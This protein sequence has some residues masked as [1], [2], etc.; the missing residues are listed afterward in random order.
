MALMMD[1]ICAE[2]NNYFVNSVED[3]HKGSFEISNGVITPSDFLLTGQYFRIVGSKLNDGVYKHGDDLSDLTDEVFDGAIWG[4]SVP[5][6]FIKTCERINEWYAKYGGVNSI[7]LS[8][9]TSESFAGYSYTKSG[10]NTGAN[11]SNWQAIFA[12]SLNK[13]RKI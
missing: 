10:E 9:Y 6:A 3:I 2:V 1:E 7:A 12:S 5:P 11:S 13:W 4:M 8:P